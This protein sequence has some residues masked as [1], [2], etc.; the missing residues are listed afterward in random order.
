MALLKP[1][2][3]IA[4]VG[5]LALLGMQAFAGTLE[6]SHFADADSDALVSHGAEVYAGNCS[7]CHGRRLQGQ[8][9]WQLRDQYEG[10]RAPPH[11]STGHTWQHPD[12]DLFHI[13][14][15]GRFAAAPASIVSYMPAFESKLKDDDIVAVIAFIKSRWPIGIRASQ[16]MLNPGY[17][18]MP[19]G[20]DKVEWTLPPN[21]TASFQRWG[22]TQQP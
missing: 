20:A 2:A 17:K 1:V 8:A 7:T 11:D 15:F 13:T 22:Q 19:A 14:K 4:G 12:E 16:S 18:G 6:P 5:I 9:L 3:I 21:C 10:R